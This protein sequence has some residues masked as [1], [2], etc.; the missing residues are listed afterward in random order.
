MIKMD[1][2][3]P[4]LQD[5][6]KSGQYMP[7]NGQQIFF[8]AEGEGEGESLILIHGFP[9]ASWDWQLLWPDLKKQFN[10][11]SP[12]MLGFGFSDK[13]KKYA[14]SIK[15]QADMFEALM[16]HLGINEAS[17]LAHDYGDTVAQE[18]LARQLEGSL[19]FNIKMITFLNGGLFPEAHRPLLIQQLLMTPLGGVLAKLM[20]KKKFAHNLQKIC[21]E[22]FSDEDVEL[23]WQL[24][25]YKDGRAV[26]PNL[27]YY[28]KE[29]RRNR[30]RW[31]GA[32]QDTN[33]PLHLI[34]GVT[35]PISG[36]HLLERFCELV[37][38]G[39]VT[40]LAGVGHYPQ[41][42]ASERVLKAFIDKQHLIRK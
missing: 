14:Y 27:I 23:L 35:D 31:V 5:W 30:S 19:C 42:E 41:V 13:P 26:I 17:I 24:L 28:M 3:S 39:Y 32:L 15:D 21:S 38:S 12:D 40:K 36:I 18:L 2:L 9:S 29:R 33:M 22:H 11:V 7:F 4:K 16:K 10:V 6:E 34:N 8:K 25:S 37:P 1:M 20:S